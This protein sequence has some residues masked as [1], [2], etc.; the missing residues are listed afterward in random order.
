MILLLLAHMDEIIWRHIIEI[1][2]D[3]FWFEI[4][5][6]DSFIVNFFKAIY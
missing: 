5:M 3:V 1:N 2:N 4:S 6:N